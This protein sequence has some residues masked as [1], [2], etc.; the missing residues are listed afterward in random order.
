VAPIHVMRFD[1]SIYHLLGDQLLGL[2]EER[3]LV[4]DPHTY[5][6][7]STCTTRLPGALIDNFTL[8]L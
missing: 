3:E 6:Q 1:E 2:T 4:F 8:T 7:R 5:E